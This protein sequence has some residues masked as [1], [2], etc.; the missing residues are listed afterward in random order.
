MK[1]TLGSAFLLL[2][3]SFAVNATET[4]CDENNEFGQRLQLKIM[5]TIIPINNEYK[6]NHFTP[7]RKA[8]TQELKKLCSSGASSKDIIEG[9]RVKCNDLGRLAPEEGNAYM[10]T[11]DVIAETVSSYV[12][13]L[14][15]SSKCAKA[16]VVSD[17]SRRSKDIAETLQ[18]QNATQTKANAK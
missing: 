4:I 6:H 3:L 5:T 16:E 9:M 1:K 10:Q 11:C 7:M 15:T 18:K 2:T 13:G 12:K 8:L 17:L 14:E